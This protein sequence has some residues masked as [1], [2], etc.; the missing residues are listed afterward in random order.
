[1]EPLALFDGWDGDF[2]WA[3]EDGGWQTSV[4]WV[5]VAEIGATLGEQSQD[6]L[7]RT[8]QPLA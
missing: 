7:A 6:G 3:S 8:H 2:A 5:N 4:V 1:V